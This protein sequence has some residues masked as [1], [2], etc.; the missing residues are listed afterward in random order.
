MSLSISFSKPF[1]Y[2]ITIFDDTLTSILSNVGRINPCD[3][4]EYVIIGQ[5]LSSI[6]CSE[7]GLE[8]IDIV[9]EVD[10]IEVSS[11]YLLFG[12]I[13]FDDNC[14]YSFTDFLCKG[15]RLSR[16]VGIFD[17]LFSNCGS[18]SDDSSCLY[19]FDDTCDLAPEIDP[20]MTRESPILY[21]DDIS[22]DICIYI[23]SIREHISS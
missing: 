18:S 20:M 23:S 5:I 17:V 16:V 11:E 13:S 6:I 19:I 12:D 22:N 1:F 3:D 8:S 14:S 15:A 10:A 9:S 4:I 2:F 21:G 7:Y